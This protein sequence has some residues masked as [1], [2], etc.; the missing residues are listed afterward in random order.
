MRTFA[1]RASRVASATD[2]NDS[3]SR[4][5]RPETLLFEEAEGTPFQT[6]YFT[7]NMVAPGIESGTS[8]YVAT[9]VD[10]WTREAVKQAKIHTDIH[11][12][13][14]IRTHDH[15]I[16]TG[17]DCSCLRPREHCHLTHTVYKQDLW[18]HGGNYEECRLLGYKNPVR[19]SQETHYFSTTE[20]SRLMLCRI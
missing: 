2:P 19:T 15:S 14:W 3:Y 16:H 20:P 12:S 4:F 18:Y 8:G 11:A 17:D 13:S 10:H 6:R 9:N 7:E 5:S 1:G